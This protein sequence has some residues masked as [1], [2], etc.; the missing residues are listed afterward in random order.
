MVCTIVIRKEVYDVI[1]SEILMAI[2]NISDEQNNVIDDINMAVLNY[3]DKR[4]T[5]MEHYDE[6][7]DDITP[8]ND[9]YILESFSKGKEKSSR[10]ILQKIWDAIKQFFK[11]MAQ[12]FSLLIDKIRNRG[13]RSSGKYVTCD[14]V[15]LRVLSRSRYNTPDDTS[16]WSIPRVNPKY[17]G[18]DENSSE[19]DDKKS[20]KKNDKV[21]TE[22]AE[23]TKYVTVNIPAGNGST[24]YPKTVK[25]PK[26][27]IIA[28]INNDEKSISFH[29]VGFGK[30]NQTEASTESSV[31]STSV[32]GTKKPWTHSSRISLYLIS[33]PSSFDKFIALTDLATEILF[34]NKHS[35]ISVFNKKCKKI[36]DSMD[37]GAKHKKLNK[38][39][40]SLKDLTV[41]QKKVND[42]NYKLDRFANIS[43]DVSRF[44]KDTIKN[45]NLLSKKLLDIQVSMNLL[46]SSLNNNLIVNQCFV[47]CIKNLALLDQFVAAMIDEGVPPKY[48]AYNTWLVADECIKGR[49]DEYKPV[50]GQTRVIF[51]PPKGKF[52]YKIAMSGAGITS[53][54]AE[55]RTSDMFVKMDRVDLIAPIVKTWEKNAIVA[56]EKVDNRSAPSY[57]EILAYTKR[58]NEAISK[59]EKE[60]KLHL[61]IAIADQ[62]RDNVKYDKV[63]KC[64][65][66]IDYGIANRAYSK[67]NKK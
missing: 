36:I 38:V 5:I 10:N 42:L 60:H 54:K 39:K 46:S 1:S 27:D 28:E 11:I 43:T 16:T 59:Y 61:N 34:D 8:Y 6:L 18:F 49:S 58:V 41:F 65:R 31:N 45:F 20:N 22:S 63:N 50:W 9:G 51:F 17:T 62:H 26:S 25:V 3:Y 33:E 4:Q 56:M 12:Q 53:N 30:W 52:V 14:S 47:G 32:E 2:D 55:A 66:S 37:H 24:F 7:S 67:H 40:V 15:V 29:I 13:S 35:H 21:I 23:D 44:D 19:K 64:Y 57:P 48:I